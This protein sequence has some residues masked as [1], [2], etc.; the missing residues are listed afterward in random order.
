MVFA[1]YVTAAARNLGIRID[2]GGSAGRV[3]ASD[4]QGLHSR[5]GALM[6]ASMPSRVGPLLA[7][8]GAALLAAGCGGT[9]SVRADTAGGGG[10]HG[11]PSRLTGAV[12][13]GAD[14][15]SGGAVARCPIIPRREPDAEQPARR[16]DPPKPRPADPNRDREF[17]RSCGHGSPAGS[18]GAVLRAEA[19]CWRRNMPA[20]VL[21]SIPAQRVRRA[22][23]ARPVPGR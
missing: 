14:A 3:G 15:Q 2:S 4:G 5:G 9:S 11:A 17:E 7:L 20:G 18:A 23:S 22:S 1:L 6:T 8:A 12:G 21:A 10:T 19:A 16:P 13:L